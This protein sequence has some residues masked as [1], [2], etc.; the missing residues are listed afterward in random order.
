MK[1]IG[2]RLRRK[3]RRR[4]APVAPRH[5]RHLSFSRTITQKQQEHEK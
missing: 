3:L 5:V 1:R 4:P 2:W